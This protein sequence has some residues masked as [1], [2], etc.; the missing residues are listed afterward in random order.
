MK[1]L[2]IKLC[3]FRQFYGETPEI[4]M[5]SGQRNTTIIHGNNGAGKTTLLNGFTWVLYEKFTDA[6]A[7]SDLL[8]NKRAITEANYGTSVDCWVRVEFEHDYKRY[9]V[10]RHCYACQDQEG[11]VQYSQSKFYMLVGNESGKWY[12]PTEQ[13]DDIIS[14]ILPENLHHYFFFDGEHIDHIFRKSDRQSIAED[15][16]DLLGVKV[17]DRS[18]A[19]LKK[20]KRTFTEE[21]SKI[22]DLDSQKLSQQNL[23]L[24]QEKAK[25]LQKEDELKTQLQNQ[26]ARKKELNQQILKLSGSNELKQL[27]L[28]L[29]KQEQILRQNLL[30]AKQTIKQLIS[31]QGYTIFTPHFVEKLNQIIVNLR[32]KGELPSGIKQ[33]FVKQL[34]ERQRCICG[35]EL[36]EGLTAY[37]Q[38]KSWMDKAGIADV[39]EAAIRLEAEAQ[40]LTTNAANFWQKIDQQQGK[41]NQYRLELSQV[42]SELDKISHKFRNYPDQ[43]IQTLQQQLDKLEASLRESQLEQGLLQQQISQLD[44]E[45]NQLLKQITKQKSKENKQALA[46]RR[47][48]ATQDAIER[49][50]L[51]R[52]HLETQ[53][54]RSLEQRVREIFSE[55]SFTPYIPRLSSDYQLTLIENTS[56]IAVPVAAST[57]E[58]QILSLSFIGAIIDRV[59]LWSEKNTLMGIDSSTFPI[60]MD[61]PFGSLDEIYRRQVAKSIPQLANQLVIL[62]TKTQ[63]RGEVE[64]ETK[65]YLGKQYVLTYYSPKEDCEE[66]KIEINGKNYPLVK[67]SVNGFEYTEIKP[68][69]DA[70][71]I[72]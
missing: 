35:T 40:T 71:S 8:V 32:Q 41:I 28:K 30:E 50:Q 11:K 27:K 24:E 1:L 69:D 7:A 72:P 10:K 58:N 54:R 63:W 45:I 68:V 65:P 53:F 4:A 43:D 62:V 66:D 21:I 47:L 20:I 67:R 18:I 55:I 5:A 25:L 64:R 46:Q 34:L 70:L 60:V 2:S 59:R 39:E 48:S 12:P 6:F 17:L 22:G 36:K 37:E 33:S 29:E 51:V 57:G 15:T 44:K 42:E 14:Q 52:K 13:P 38:V 9:Q 19:H 3:N 26:E 23:K 31:R 16:K 56:G 61:S 49:I